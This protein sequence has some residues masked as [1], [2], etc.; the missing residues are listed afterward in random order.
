MLL[1]S[2]KISNKVYYK[3]IQMEIHGHL[4]NYIFDLNSP[5]QELMYRYYD[6]KKIY[7]EDIVSSLKLLEEGDLFIDVGAHVGYFS[8][9]ASKLVK[10]SGSVISFEPNKSNRKS[11]FKNISIN[12]CKNVT[13]CKNAIFSECCKKRFY[14]N[15]DNDGGHCFWDPS[16]HNFNIIT[17]LSKNNDNDLI[18]CVSLDSCEKIKEISKKSKIV[19]KID[20]EGAELDV[21]KGSDSLLKN[22]FLK[23][24]IC[25]IN[26]LGLKMMG[27]DY[28]KLINFFIDYNFIPY[29]ILSNGEFDKFKKLES[30][31]ENLFFLRKDK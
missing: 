31:I 17:R 12:N 2:P 27:Y 1:I 28:N 8:M 7:G 3:K 11:L 15:Q 4:I 18:D 22:P 14:T 10:E 23:M 9:I 20:T 30:G 5:S 13:V 29:V 21:L 24:V 6:Y 16:I 25:E 19:L 26:E